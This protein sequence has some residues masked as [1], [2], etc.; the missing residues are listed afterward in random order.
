M[1]EELRQQT[2][3]LRSDAQDLRRKARK[4]PAQQAR[5]DLF[6][7]AAAKFKDAIGVLERGLRQLRRQGASTSPS[8]DMCKLLELVS[9]TY[10]SLGGTWRDAG[11]LSAALAQYETGDRYE[12]ERRA[13]CHAQDSYNMVQRRVLQLMIQPGLLEQPGFKKEM[14]QVLATIVTQFDRGRSDTWGLADLV[15][16]RILCGAEAADAASD[17]TRR[18]EDL[19]K[20]SA[21]P[22]F[23]ESTFHA[24]AAL[25]DEALGRDVR[26]RLEELKQLMHRKGGLA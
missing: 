3:Q 25:A 6:K 20:T 5:D 22:N 8:S 7:Q 13:Q 1:F 19:E 24:V 12:E 15:L 2:A 4:E 9:Q 21:D 11:D 18:I 10:G 23:Y 26:E 17:L 14:N 16:M